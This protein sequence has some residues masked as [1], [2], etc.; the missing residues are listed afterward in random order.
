VAAAAA[1]GALAV[2]AEAVINIAVRSL[3]SIFKLRK[4]TAAMAF[5]LSAGLTGQPNSQRC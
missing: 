3:P 4:R 5:S 2:V 1:V